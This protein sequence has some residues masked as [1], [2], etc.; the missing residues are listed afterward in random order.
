MISPKELVQVSVLHVLKNHDERVALHTHSVEGDDVLVLQVGEKLRLSVE[1]CATAFSGLLQS[2]RDRK[3]RDQQERTSNG[4]CS[5]VFLK[6]ELPDQYLDGHMDLLM[7][8]HQVI[9]L[10]KKDFPEG[11]FSQ[12]PLQHNIVPLDVLH[13]FNTEQVKSLTRSFVVGMLRKRFQLY[14]ILKF[15]QL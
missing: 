1:V 11:S 3:R 7:V 10:G 4:N 14:S 15:D 8:W 12:L 9:A 13:N 5:P 6:K 2:L